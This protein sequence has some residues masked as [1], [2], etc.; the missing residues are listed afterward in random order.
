M[1]MVTEETTVKEITI[2][3]KSAPH[4]EFSLP[5]SVTSDASIT[6]LATEVSALIKQR[7]HQHGAILIRGAGDVSI[8]S[9]GQ[10][11]AATTGDSINYDF[12]STPRSRIQSG[13]YTATEYPAHQTIPLHNEQSYTN[14]W[15]DY[16]WFYCEKAAVSGGAT[17]L[18][19]SREIFRKIPESI[20]QKF[21]DKGVMYVRNYG[22]GYD[23]DW[24][25]VFNTTDRQEVE[26]FCHKRDIQFEWKSEDELT[27]TQVCQAHTV[28]KV[29]GETVWFNQAHLFHV[30]SL[31][32]EI[33]EAL[34]EILGIEGL[35]RN[36][37]YGDGSTIED[38]VLDEIRGIYD[39]NTVIFPWQ[40]GDIMLVDNVLAAHGRQAFEG[41]RKVYVMMT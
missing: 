11:V 30:S 2:E 14:I 18:A 20:R 26:S 5:Y 6:S 17:T 31:A 37:C 34:V 15:A 21:M 39:E 16:L 24:Q 22:T 29:T 28:H 27:T 8:D 23:L 9:F 7:L 19:D 3:F 13:V 1:V 4:A 25:K 38:S 41:D 10:L 32:P 33:R 35:P 40:A 12:G 36:A